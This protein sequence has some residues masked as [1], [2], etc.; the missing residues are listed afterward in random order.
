[1]SLDSRCDGNPEAFALLRGR[2]CVAVQAELPQHSV[3]QRLIAAPVI[4]ARHHSSMHPYD[5]SAGAIRTARDKVAG[6]NH[7]RITRDKVAGTD[8][9]DHARITRIT[10]GYAGD[11]RGH[12]PTLSL[13]QTRERSGAGCESALFD[14]QSLEHGDVKVA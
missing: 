7:A 8:H 12:G 10:C 5:G 13:L 3:A 4:L 9:A 2:W 1:M 6:T 11:D 14:A